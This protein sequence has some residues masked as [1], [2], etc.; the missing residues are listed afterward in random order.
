M[1]ISEYVSFAGKDTETNKKNDKKTTT[2]YFDFYLYTKDNVRKGYALPSRRIKY[3]K[4][5]KEGERMYIIKNQIC[6]KIEF[7]KK[8]LNFL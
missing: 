3:Y 8:I 6:P 4:G 5:L 7:L 2:N 1:Q